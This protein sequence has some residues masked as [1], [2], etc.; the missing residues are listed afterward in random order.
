MGHRARNE[1]AA[2]ALDQETFLCAHQPRAK[3]AQEL[4]RAEESNDLEEI[5]ERRAFDHE[6]V[7]G[8][9]EDADP[10]TSED[11]EIEPDF[12]VFFK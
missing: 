1:T 3:I 12:L 8:D 4:E 7:G 6:D 2:K 11:D 5:C 9:R 10:K